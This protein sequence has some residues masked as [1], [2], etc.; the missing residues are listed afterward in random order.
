MK[1]RL[2]F[3]LN[4]INQVQVNPQVGLTFASGLRSIL[5]Q[6]PDIVMIGE[7]RDQETAEIAIRASMTGHLVLSTLHTNSALATIPRLLDMEV[8][9]YLVVSSLIGSC[10]ATACFVKFVQ[11]VK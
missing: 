8:E 6:D 4:G 11:N 7:I 2:N 5:R 3:R 10:C 9:P 1:I